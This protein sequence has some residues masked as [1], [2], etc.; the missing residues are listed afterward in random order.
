MNGVEKMFRLLVGKPEGKG[1]WED[2]DIRRFITL[3]K[4]L[5][6]DC[7]VLTELGWLKIGMSGELL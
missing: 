4:I 5:E 7:G 2:L 6:R 3:R 1:K